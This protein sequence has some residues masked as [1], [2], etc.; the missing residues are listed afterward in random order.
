MTNNLAGVPSIVFGLFGMALFV[1][2]LVLRLDPCRWI[3]FRLIGFT[4][5]HKNYGGSTKSG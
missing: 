2:K 4:S 3:N 5:Y 1:N